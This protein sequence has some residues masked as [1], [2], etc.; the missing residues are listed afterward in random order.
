MHTK[1]TLA[2]MLGFAAFTTG[3]RNASLLTMYGCSAGAA[4][5]IP[6]SDTLFNDWVNTF[7]AALTANPTDV[8]LVAGDASTFAGLVSTW[9][10]AY[11]L[12][13][14]DATRTPVTVQAKIDARNIVEPAARV[15]VIQI[16]AFPG[17][18]NEERATFGLTVP[19][20]N[21][22]P[23]PTPGTKPVANIEDIGNLLHVIRLRDEL[24]P[25]SNAKPDGAI[26]AEIWYKTGAVAPVDLTGCTYAGLATTR[27]ATVT[28]APA[29]VGEQAHYL[30][31]WIN[32]KGDTGPLSDKIEATIAA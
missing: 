26:G 16:Q 11:A 1:R 13:I 4:D 6:A 5:Y 19:D 18:S 10:A 32:G 25:T 3:A 31:R 7:G 8:G 28:H 27:F 21:P 17:T 9:N 23:V 29:N 2:Q 14:D 22:T 12:V 20:L 24:T 15:L 30:C